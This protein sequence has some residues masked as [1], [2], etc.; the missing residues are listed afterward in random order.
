MD[1]E[2]RGHARKEA[3][4][5]EVIPVPESD[6]AKQLSEDTD[7]GLGYKLKDFPYAYI[8]INPFENHSEA[9]LKLVG[10]ERLSEG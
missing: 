8:P 4:T 9:A 6:S 1:H 5:A 7:V 3:K 10:A 2:E